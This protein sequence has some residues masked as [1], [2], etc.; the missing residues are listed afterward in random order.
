MRIMGD[1][2]KALLKDAEFWVGPREE[3]RPVC[4]CEKCNVTRAKIES[5]S[6]FNVD[7]CTDSRAIEKGDIYCAIPGACVDG[8]DFLSD[9][10]RAGA[11]GFIVHCSR[12]EKIQKISPRIMHG[13]L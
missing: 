4:N 11:S 9:S 13:K 3:D 5:D 10:L 8:H 12:I 7:F 1:F 2:L 6:G